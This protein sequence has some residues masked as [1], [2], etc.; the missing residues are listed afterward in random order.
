MV[1][2]VIFI[3]RKNFCIHSDWFCELWIGIR[4]AKSKYLE[5]SNTDANDYRLKSPWPLKLFL[6]Q[7]TLYGQIMKSLNQK[8]Y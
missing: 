3:S 6:M 2:K 8:S 7:P 4:G 5:C 1:S